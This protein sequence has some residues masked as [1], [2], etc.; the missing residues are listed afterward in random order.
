M[1]PPTKTYRAF[2][3]I[4]DPQ[5]VVALKRTSQE[6]A[7]HCTLYPNAKFITPERYG[8]VVGTFTMR[9]STQM[10][11]IASRLRAAYSLYGG[12]RVESWDKCLELKE[13][14]CVHNAS[15]V[16]VRLMLCGPDKH[17]ISTSLVCLH[18]DLFAVVGNLGGKMGDTFFTPYVSVGQV[19]SPVHKLGYFMAKTQVTPFIVNPL[20]FVLEI[21][22]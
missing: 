7:I 19:I 1:E 11:L 6:Y 17:C 20:D 13:N 3:P 21:V 12:M 8:M 10:E 16:M 14:K 5:G 15:D 22:K 18:G 4:D 9:S 2:I